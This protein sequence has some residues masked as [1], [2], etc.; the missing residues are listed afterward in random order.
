MLQFGSAS[1][2]ERPAIK[3]KRFVAG[4]LKRLC[5]SHKTAPLWSSEEKKGRYF[6]NIIDILLLKRQCFPELFNSQ[7]SDR[8]CPRL[9]R[10][11]Q[12]SGT[13]PLPL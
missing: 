7:L 2:T 5:C 3:Q 11:Q 13:V 1:R 9:R 12:D 8:A 10:M 4:M 6:T